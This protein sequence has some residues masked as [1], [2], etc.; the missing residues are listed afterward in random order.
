MNL[1]RNCVI[2]MT[3]D[4]F[5]FIAIDNTVQIKFAIIMVGLWKVSGFFVTPGEKNGSVLA[6]AYPGQDLAGRFSQEAFV[7]DD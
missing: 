4:T 7:G 6:L 3:H 2:Y 1:N 5:Y